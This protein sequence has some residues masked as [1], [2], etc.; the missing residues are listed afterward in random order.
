MWCFCFWSMLCLYRRRLLSISLARSRSLSLYD[1]DN[2]N[3][4]GGNVD[5]V[6][7][8]L[9]VGGQVRLLSSK[10][11]TFP[12][13][14]PCARR[15]LL[16]GRARPSR[17]AERLLAAAAGA[18]M[19]RSNLACFS[20]VITKGKL[21]SILC[22]SLSLSLSLSRSLCNSPICNERSK[23]AS[24]SNLSPLA[25]LEC[26]FAHSL[27]RSLAHSTPPSLAALQISQVQ[28]S[29]VQFAL[30]LCVNS[31]GESEQQQQPTGKSQ[32]W[33]SRSKL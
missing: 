6:L 20:H 32:R 27:A 11:W 24:S 23:Q 2:D 5:V 29:L 12:Y 31:I 1:D 22:N 30:C 33:Y 17:A 15:E 10:A 28:I 19:R 16:T 4:D 13:I 3:D 21:R 9:Q 7:C 14:L 25:S 8:C 26:I 18:R